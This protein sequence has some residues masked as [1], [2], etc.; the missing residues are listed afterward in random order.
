MDI[1]GKEAAGGVA[2]SSEAVTLTLGVAVVIG[3]SDVCD[4][5]AG[6]LRP[7]LRAVVDTSPTVCSFVVASA[8]LPTFFSVTLITGSVC[9]A[10]DFCAA[11]VVCAA[12]VT[13]AARA[14]GGLCFRT[15]ITQPS[16]PRM[17]LLLQC[18]TRLGIEPLIYYEVQTMVSESAKKR[19]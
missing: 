10:V 9:A 2:T 14:T 12:C 11:G 19:K 15:E 17:C 18:F 3:A 7:F 4:G 6:D 16:G 1:A 13:G 5:A 8:F